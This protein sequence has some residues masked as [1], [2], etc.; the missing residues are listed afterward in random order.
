[1]R[2]E[3]SIGSTYCR[4]SR[5]AQ[6]RP[7]P[8][9]SSAAATAPNSPACRWR[10]S[11]GAR[12]ISYCAAPSAIA[13]KLGMEVGGFR[14]EDGGVSIGLRR[15]AIRLSEHGDALIGADGLRS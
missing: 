8:S 1:M 10:A 6:W 2:R 12:P 7:A 4:R 11:A 13:L 15:G 9:E 3:F 5:P 14:E